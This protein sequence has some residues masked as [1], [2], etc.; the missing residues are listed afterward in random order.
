MECC[1]V[2][3]SVPPMVLRSEQCLAPLLEPVM[4]PPMV[5]Q[6]VLLWLEHL[7][8]HRPALQQSDQTS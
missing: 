3:L 6:L 8:V 7:M 2:P 1:L 4:V 5:M